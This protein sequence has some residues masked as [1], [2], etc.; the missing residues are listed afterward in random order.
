MTTPLESKIDRPHLIRNYQALTSIH[1]TLALVTLELPFGPLPRGILKKMSIIQLD[2]Y[3]YGRLQA[4]LNF[5]M[6]L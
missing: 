4:L 1:D 5:L 6:N 2:F 3:F